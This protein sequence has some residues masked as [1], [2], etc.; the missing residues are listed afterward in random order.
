[1]HTIF[2]ATL[3]G[4]TLMVQIPSLDLPPKA[5]CQMF[6]LD[7]YTE[8]CL[9]NAFFKPFRCLLIF[10]LILTKGPGAL[11]GE[12]THLIVN[13]EGIGLTLGAEMLRVLVHGE[14]HLLADP[15]DEDRVPVLV[16]QQAAQGG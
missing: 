6:F 2:N 13:V 1:M 7:P 5:A 9:P 14:V 16:V 12:S 4:P 10:S 15:L 8:G 3:H 11:R